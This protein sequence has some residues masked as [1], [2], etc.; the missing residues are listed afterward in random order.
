ME[1]AMTYDKRAAYEERHNLKQINIRLNAISREQLDQ[2]VAIYGDKQ[3]ALAV[4][5]EVAAAELTKTETKD[6]KRR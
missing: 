4:A 3:R 2:L 1:T 6:G 5:L